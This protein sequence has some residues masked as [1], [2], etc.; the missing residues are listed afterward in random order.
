MSET[1][2]EAYQKIIDD[3]CTCDKLD[4][5]KC[6]LY[7]NGKCE[8]ILENEAELSYC[9]VYLIRKYLTNKTNPKQ[10]TQKIKTLITSQ[11]MGC[12]EE[13]ESNPPCKDP[14]F[15]CVFTELKSAGEDKL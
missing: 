1:K 14:S 5:L 12:T 8:A 7:E 13:N 2:L 9:E 11:C 4:N 3:Y 15:Y 6:S 10:T